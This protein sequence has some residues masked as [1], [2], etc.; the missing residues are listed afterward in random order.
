MGTNAGV[1]SEGKLVVFESCF[2]LLREFK[3]AETDPRNVHDLVG[4]DHALDALRYALAELPVLQSG[5]PEP[6][7]PLARFVTR[8]LRRSGVKI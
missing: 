7:D 6:T 5:R 3:E 1:D 4:D 2:N 8:S